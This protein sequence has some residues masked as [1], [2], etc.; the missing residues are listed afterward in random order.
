M[1]QFFTL[2]G[3]AIGIKK[4][5]RG[6]WFIGSELSGVLPALEARVRFDDELYLPVSLAP[7]L[8]LPPTHRIRRG[9]GG[10]VPTAQ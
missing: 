2:R 10:D 8:R 1:C 3:D 7:H 6:R 9:V 4:A 5:T